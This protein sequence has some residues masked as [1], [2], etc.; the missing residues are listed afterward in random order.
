MENTVPFL[1]LNNCEQVQLRKMKTVS[2]FED[3]QK[4]SF[5]VGMKDNLIILRFHPYF[6]IKSGEILHFFYYQQNP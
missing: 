3:R 1:F 2:E 6:N 4:D 5:C